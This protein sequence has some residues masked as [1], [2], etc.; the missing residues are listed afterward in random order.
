MSATVDAE[1]VTVAEAARQLQVHQATIRRWLD[2]GMLTAYR[3]GRRRLLIKRADLLKLIAPAYP[4]QPQPPRMG[5]TNPV[6]IP[7]ITPAPDRQE[8]VVPIR[9][10][11]DSEVR[12]GLEALERSRAS[13]AAMLA[14]RGGRELPESWPIIRQQR[15]AR[16][17]LK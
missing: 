14:R 11:T 15:A 9:L 16:S 8:P 5:T 10:L 3:M 7:E 2:A 12:Q 17:R 6:V 13:R 4:T 1:Y